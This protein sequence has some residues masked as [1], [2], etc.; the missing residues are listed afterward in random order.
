[1]DYSLAKEMKNAGFPQ[2]KQAIKIG[3][4][5]V[6]TLSELIEACG[7]DFDLLTHDRNRSFRN[8]YR[9][10][11][12]WWATSWSRQEGG[13]STPEE[14]VARL[15]LALNAAPS[16]DHSPA[17]SPAPTSSHSTEGSSGE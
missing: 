5:Y 17:S 9:E 4:P 10:E 6:P 12:K 3:L 16:D 14:A 11:H 8:R 2:G 15:Y 1:M 7:D 13:G